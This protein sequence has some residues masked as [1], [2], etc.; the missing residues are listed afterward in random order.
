MPTFGAAEFNDV[1]DFSRGEPVDVREE[2]RRGQERS[3]AV[4]RVA[5]AAEKSRSRSLEGAVR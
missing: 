2:Q 1:A 5:D 4:E 3:A